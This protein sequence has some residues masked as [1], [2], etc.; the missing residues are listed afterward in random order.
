M[1][2]GEGGQAMKNIWVKLLSS[3]VILVLAGLWIIL[4]PGP[5]FSKINTIN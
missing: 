1:S 5:A 3:I 2:I 4:S